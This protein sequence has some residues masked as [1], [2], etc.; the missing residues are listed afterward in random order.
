MFIFMHVETEIFKIVN[1]DQENVIV[2]T[3]IPHMH[4]VIKKMKKENENS[5]SKIAWKCRRVFM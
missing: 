1:I 2:A 3:A 4:I 5:L